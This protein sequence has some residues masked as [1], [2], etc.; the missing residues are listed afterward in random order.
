MHVQSQSPILYCGTPVV[1]ISTLNEDGTANLSPM[2]S[3]WWLGWR[4]MLG[5]D[6]SSKTTENLKRT[7]QCVLNLPS[8]DMVAQV[9]AIARTTGSDPIPDGKLMR[10]YRTERRK[11][12]TAGLTA[13]DSEIVAPPRVLECPVQMEATVT[14]IGDLAQGDGVFQGFLNTVQVSIERLHLHESIIQDGNPDRVDPDKWR[15]LIM[16]FA[17][18]YGLADGKLQRSELADI[19]AESYPRAG[20]E[21]STGGIAMPTA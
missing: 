4:C 5:L 2:S 1:L 3:A 20:G 15:P 13:V 19:P 14:Q 10:G 11:F 8:A 9:D 18:F 12:E 17:D 21:S 16:M 6:A 7:G